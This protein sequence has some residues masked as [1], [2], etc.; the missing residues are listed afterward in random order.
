[1]NKYIKINLNDNV[2]IAIENLTPRDI[3]NI[4]G[5]PITIKDTIK[6]GH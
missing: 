2:C 6:T 1:M 5:T 4:E 3:I